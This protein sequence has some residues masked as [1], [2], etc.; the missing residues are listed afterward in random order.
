VGNFCT[1][2]RET[3]VSNRTLLNVFE[4]FENS[5]D[6]KQISL[7]QSALFRFTL[8][9]LGGRKPS[10]SRLTSKER[11]TGRKTLDSI[12]ITAETEERLREAQKQTFILLNIPKERQRQPRFYLNQFIE[13]AIKN[14]FFPSF[15]LPEENK[16]STSY[17]KKIYQ[18]KATN[19][20]GTPK[21]FIFSFEP[22]NYANE[23][24]N[25]EQI[26]HHLNRIKEELTRFENYQITIPQNRAIT[27]KKY[28][29][30][31][32]LILGWLYRERNIPLAELSLNKLVPLVELNPRMS[33]F[34][35]DENPWLSQIIAKAKALEQ[36]KDK[37][38]Y[39]VDLMMKFFSWLN[40]PPLY[41]TKQSYVDALIAYSKYVYQNETDKT[42][43]LN[44][45]D[46]PI[47]NRLKVFHRELKTGKKHTSSN[48]NNKYLPW[49][50]VINVLEKLKFEANLETRKKGARRV[51]YSLLSRAKSLQNF[52]L[53]GFFT[54][55]PPPRQRVV[56]ELELGR[57]LKYGLF[58]NGRFLP[59]GRMA[60][61]SEAKYYIHL[62]PEDYKTGDSYGEWLGEF[63]NVE[64]GDGSK[65]YDYV[66]RWLFQ[67]YQDK[68]SGKWHGMRDLV[69]S[70]GEKT[71]FVTSTAKRSHDETSMC[72]VVKRI[73]V[74]WTGVS[75]SPH[76]L[77][78]LYRTYIDNPET[79]TSTEERE[80]AAFWMRHSSEMAKE[81]YSHL[82]CEQKLQLGAQMSERLNRQLLNHKK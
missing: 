7:C 36:I 31:L 55:V 38:H 8:P 35:N 22:N 19:R 26:Q 18:V 76:D 57:T 25:I 75:I 67:G 69:A 53:L 77:R 80:S 46:I 14:E 4:N 61:S 30:V 41:R 50:D 59:V 28:I 49:S 58:E 40:H 37:A 5:C 73:F 82:N 66:N 42:M 52:V 21:K 70:A 54:L 44:F 63:P 39:L 79:G 43:A 27:I 24:L 33:E 3:L 78:K 51:K 48:L 29:R 23:P 1:E 9:G 60:N 17:A 32:Q 65:F 13:W 68:E 72:K 81:V 12:S 16:E 15:D 34:S 10:G 47:V 62:Q 20:V 64:F 74:R 6:T 56:R 45:E 11:D 71:V 2:K